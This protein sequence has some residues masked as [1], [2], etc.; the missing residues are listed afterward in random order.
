M[1]IVYYRRRIVY[2]CDIWALIFLCH[3][4]AYYRTLQFGVYF[5]E[6]VICVWFEAI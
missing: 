6:Y 1:H 5:P 2:I 4:L 3:L